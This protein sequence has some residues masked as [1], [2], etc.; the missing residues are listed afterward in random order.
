MACQFFPPDIGGE[1]RHV[2]ALAEHLAALGHD[3]A[4][5][6]QQVPDA[7]PREI[8]P[9]GVRIHRIATAAMA[10]PVYST[11]RAHHAPLPDPRAVVELARV[12]REE[13]PQVVHAHNWIVNSLLPL[14]S[15]AA[16]GVGPI[17]RHGLVLTLHD[18]SN[19]CA[20]KRFMY[21]GALCSG[22]APRRCLECSIDHY[23]PLVGPLTAGATAAMRPWKKLAVDKIHCVSRAVAQHNGLADDPR[24]S[25]VPNFVPDARLDPPPVTDGLS[26]ELPED[27]LFFAGDL[28]REKGVDVLLRAYAALPQPR[29]ALVLVGR[30]TP[31]TPRELP[32]GAI[33]F[34]SWPHP[35]VMRGFAGCRFAVLPSVWPDPCPTTVLEAMATGRPVITTSTGGMIDMVRHG[36]SGLLVPPGDDVDLTAAMQR[37]LGSPSEREY[38]GAAGAARVRDHFTASAVVERLLDGYR[39]VAPASGAPTMRGSR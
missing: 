9:S 18:Y 38:F 7:P 11:S 23:G 33:V 6:T 13:R 15:G 5:A 37:L 29:P 3:V 26:T 17:P 24:C 4:V 28:S 30:R 25:V 35:D 1:E 20:T 32:E 12:V 2:H 31:D 21:D 22:P 27:Y 14:R 39:E 36:V 8:T 34:E 16:G 19:V 10:L